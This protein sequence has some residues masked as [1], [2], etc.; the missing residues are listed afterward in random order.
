MKTILILNGPTL[1]RLGK[2][3]PA[4]YGTQT[5]DDLRASLEPV[6]ARLGVTLAF[7]QYNGEGEMVDAIHSVADGYDGCVVNAGAYTHYS[8]AIRDAIAS[9]DKP[10]VEVHLTNVHAREDFRARSVIAPVCKGSVAGF[11]FLSYELA[12]TALAR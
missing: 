3:E 12:L 2:R 4:L 11:G 10:F 7:A 9:V 6:A 5:L 1:D 8:L